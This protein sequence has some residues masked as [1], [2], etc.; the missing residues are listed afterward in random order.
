[1]LS[2]YK[3]CRSCADKHI[4]C[5]SISRWSCINNIRQAQGQKPDS[6]EIQE[7]DEGEMTSVG[8]WKRSSTCEAISSSFCSTMPRQFEA[9]RCMLLFKIGLECARSEWL[10]R[11][12]GYR[13][14]SR[15]CFRKTLH[16]QVDGP[17]TAHGSDSRVPETSRTTVLSGGQT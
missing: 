3:S 11:C 16:S 13:C 8:Q 10:P 1:M 2:Q 9:G 17:G 5:S 15:A 6:F 12:L 7:H 14:G 4:I